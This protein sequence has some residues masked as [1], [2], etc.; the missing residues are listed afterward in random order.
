VSLLTACQAVAEETGLLSSPATVVGN[1]DPG[2]VQLF[3]L[4]K[5]AATELMD[6]RDWQRF[7]R[8]HTITTVSGTDS[9]ALPSDWSRYL[10]QTAWDATNYWPMRGSIDPQQWQALKRGIVVLTIR[11][12]YRVMGNLVY[13]IPTP[14][15]S[16]ESL[17][18]EY[19]RNTPWTDSTGATYRT[20]PTADTD[21]SV[22]AENLIVLDTKWRLKHA[23]GLDYTEDKAEAEGAVSLAYAQ[24]VPAMIVNDGLPSNFT[25]P[26]YPVVPQVI[27]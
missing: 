19:M 25:P 14:T 2:V 3:A 23:K 17:I 18:I 16:N 26:F 6:A 1:T 15:V 13:I 8:E 20:A 22:L 12:R 5:R 11:K 9:Y 7:R 4:M 21:L 24:D 10:S 27:Q